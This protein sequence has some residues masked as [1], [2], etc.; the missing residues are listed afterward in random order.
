MKKRALFCALYIHNYDLNDLFFSGIIY[1]KTNECKFYC[2][3]IAYKYQRNRLFKPF[4]VRFV[5]S[6]PGVRVPPSAPLKNRKKHL[7]WLA[8]AVFYF[9]VSFEKYCCV[10]SYFNL[11]QT[12]LQTF[13]ALINRLFAL[14]NQYQYVCNAPSWRKM[15]VP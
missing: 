9:F 10:F 1:K 15:H 14:A 3:F 13:T 2:S 5:I 11:L 6:R 12:V 8:F 4:F 7:K